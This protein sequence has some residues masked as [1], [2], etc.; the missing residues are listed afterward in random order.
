[1]RYYLLIIITFL[2]GHIFAQTIV[3]DGPACPGSTVTYQGPPNCGTASGAWIVTPLSARVSVSSPGVTNQAE[4]EWS[5]T[6]SGTAQ[7]LYQYVA[8]EGGECGDAPQSVS[9]TVSPP[10]I[11]S[12]QINASDANPCLNDE[13]E[14]TATN[15]TGVEWFDGETSLGT[16][17]PISVVISE[18]MDIT[19]TGDVDYCSGQESSSGSINITVLPSPNLSLSDETYSF[20]GQ[21]NVVIAPDIPTGIS[22]FIWEDQQ[23]TAVVEE[24]ILDLG[25]LDEGTYLYHL[26]GQDANGCKT[27][28]FAIIDINVQASCNSSLNH[29]TATSYDEYGN[30]ISGSRIYFDLVGQVVQNQ[31]KGFTD[32]TI[33]VNQPV[34]DRLYRPVINTLNAP[35]LLTE[36][37]YLENFVTDNNGDPYGYLNFDNPLQSFKFLNPDPISKTSGLG[38]Y[39]STGNTL[40]ASVPVTD[41]PYARVEYY[42]D[43][44]EELKRST[45]P[46]NRYKLGSGK[47][48]K[49]ERLSVTDELDDYLTIRNKLFEVYGNTTLQSQAIKEVFVDQNDIRSEIV[50][51]KSGNV[52]ITQNAKFPGV[53]NRDFSNGSLSPW[54]NLEQG[55]LR[56]A[57]SELSFDHELRAFSM[58]GSE[59][60]TNTL[61]NDITILPGEYSAYIQM[62]RGNTNNVYSIFI[63]GIRSDGTEVGLGSQFVSSGSFDGTIDFEATE[64]YEAIGL[65]VSGVPGTGN[66]DVRLGYIDIQ[67]SGSVR[68]SNTSFNYYDGANRLIASIAPNGVLDI[69]NSPNGVDDFD[70]NNL[71]FT[72]YYAYNHQGWLES[73]REPDVGETKYRY[74]KDG[75]I[76]YS[77]NAQQKVGLDFSYTDYDSLGRPIE[78]GEIDIIPEA[79]ENT[80]DF[81][82]INP[83]LNP[84]IDDLLSTID[85]IPGLSANKRQWVKTNYDLPD[86][87]FQTVTKLTDYNQDFVLGAVSWTENK[88]IKTWYSYDEQGRV[89]WMAQKPVN[90]PVTFVIE[91]NYDLLGNVLQVAYKSYEPDGTTKDQFF[92][93]YQ[94]DADKRLSRTLTSLDG[95]IDNAQLQAKYIYYLHGPLKRIELANDLQGIDFVYNIQGWLKSINH[96]D[97][98]PGLDPGN[99]GGG[100]GF[101]KDV[102]GMILN[103][104][105]NNMNGLFQIS[106]LDNHPNP[107]E[108]H[109]LAGEE[110]QPIQIASMFDLFMPTMQ[111]PNESGF[112]Q[113]SAEKPR[114]GEQLKR[115]LDQQTSDQ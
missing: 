70:I 44:T 63:S 96:P 11:P 98:D 34:Y 73:T 46:G 29:I 30:P 69:L 56:W 45:I 2:S 74:R 72:T 5:S 42:D 94:Y 8:F 107:L 111:A 92:H 32:G 80:L 84:T 82:F 51:D 64:E 55:D 81:E 109:G 4:V 95:N 13:I 1:M 85:R 77:Q 49:T 71:P 9:I 93:H 25:Q 100:N 26:F 24:D 113:Y 52:L 54:R 67:P 106:A 3:S 87:D 39:Y 16:T 114:Y 33:L 21:Q 79:P 88:D 31:T 47:E 108:F 90:L 19:V 65:W 62:A 10:T 78:F 99:D 105:E 18:D 48:V 83:N 68:F 115:L 89:E 91:Y 38:Q 60:N 43:G 101:R 112:K 66:L 53:G 102:F 57:Y 12:V 86:F 36:F 50:E 14:L 110:F 20:C 75:S 6:F 15:A 76:R 27:T 61:V 104:Y 41:F 28:D 40:E 17:N 35:F 59:C 97:S 23:S 103:Y 37:S 58:D 7:I 22:S